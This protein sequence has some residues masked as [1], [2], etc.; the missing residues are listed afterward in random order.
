M[1]AKE[2][3]KSTS[4]K[5]IVT[6]LS[7]LLVCGIF[8][9]VMY[10]LL[11]V[12]DEERF[13]RA[14]SKIYGKNVT[15]EEVDIS[16]KNTS[17]SLASIDSLY[18]VKDDGN[19]LV[20]SSGKN[21][22]GGTV[23]CWVV[24][25]VNEDGTAVNGVGKV[26]I[27][28]AAGESYINYISSSNLAQFEKDYEEGIIYSYGWVNG[29]T[30]HGDMY[31][32]TGASCSYRAICNAVNGAIEF[33]NAYVSGVEIVN[34]YENFLFYDFIDMEKTDWTVAD[35]VINYSIVTTGHG[36]PQSFTID[37]TVGADKT[38]TKFDIK[39]NGSTGEPWLGNM[40]ATIKDGTMFVGKGVDFF[41]ALGDETLS[42]DSVKGDSSIKT[43]ATK[44]NYLCVMA[45]AFATANYDYCLEN[46]KPE[47]NE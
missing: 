23:T 28:K 10:G 39:T 34:P 13:Q 36:E 9:T 33:T 40:A 14:I 20:K 1:T 15:T 27:D 45:G 42:Y 29:G 46:E 17:L 26:A 19:Y 37:V 43:G 47:V 24:V 38:I 44:S 25:K 7:I 11:E 8:L 32:S 35:G 3:F 6:L 16:E 22:Y 31:I 2:F 4:F 18:Y 12:T 21:G 30:A 41:T 5:C